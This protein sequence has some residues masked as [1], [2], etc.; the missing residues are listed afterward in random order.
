[1]EYCIVYINFDGANFVK[2]RKYFE[3]LFSK[4]TFTL[5]RA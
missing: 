1:M 3:Q 4:Y 5:K 2:L